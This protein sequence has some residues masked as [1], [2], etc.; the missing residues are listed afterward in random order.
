MSF[1]LQMSSLL[2]ITGM[3][4]V[5]L[6]TRWWPQN[7]RI[8][9]VLF[10]LG[11]LLYFDIRVLYFYI[12]YTF[13]NYL[14]LIFLC[15]TL[16]WRKT[17]FI[18][19]IV[20][21]LSAVCLFRMSHMGVTNLPLLNAIVTLGIMYNVLKVIDALYFAYFFGKDGQ[22]KLLDYTNFLLF[23]PTF[24]SG[25]ILKFRDFISDIKQPYQVT[26][27]QFEA[28]TKRVILGLFKKVVVVVLMTDLLQY[29][30]GKDVLYTQHSLFLMVWF[31]I[32]IY[33]DFSGYSDIAVGFGR[34]MG[35]NIPENFKK[36]FH[37]LTLTQFWRNWHATLGDWFRDHIFIFFS[38]KT[39]S[40]L[41]AASL[42]IVVM[43]LMGLWHNFT[44]LFVLYGLYHGIIIALENLFGKTTVNRK[45]VSKLYFYFRWALTQGLIILA[46]II[47]MDDQTTILRIYRGLFN[48]PNW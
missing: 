8:L 43:L 48:F 37:S 42:S 44:W 39:P 23:V 24:T 40:K 26:A 14:M 29:V 34:L 21:N 3:V 32:L 11:F 12:I 31:Y 47:N 35:Y 38:R 27:E 18:F 28:G 46:I 30:L 9:L 19:F 6:L 2:A 16:T 4:L 13:I 45:R 36:P 5:L 17:T 1:Y 25:P 41:T 7:K 33:M 15:R 20:L 22:V 10:N